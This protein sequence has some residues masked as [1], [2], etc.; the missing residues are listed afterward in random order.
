LA[1]LG[2]SLA[3]W[4]ERWFPDPLVFAL[5]GILFVFLTGLCLREP[6]GKLAVQGVKS[7]WTLVPFTMQMVMIIIGGYVVATTPLVNRLI[8]ALARLSFPC[9]PRSSPGD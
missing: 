6:P 4:S 9:L 1:R 8:A 5:L 3:D 7:F 2:L